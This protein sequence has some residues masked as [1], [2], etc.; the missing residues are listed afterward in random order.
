MKVWRREKL[1]YARHLMADRTRSIPDIC[2]ELDDMP[3]STLNHY[4]HAD[5]TLKGPGR[6]LFDAQAG[7]EAAG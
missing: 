3:G 4:L 5:G 2:W 7:P 6:R 1:R